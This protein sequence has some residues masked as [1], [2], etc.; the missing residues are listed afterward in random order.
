MSIM[1]PPESD[2]GVISVSRALAL[3]ACF[4]PDATTLSLAQLSVRSGLHKT[5]ALRLARTLESAEYLVQREGGQW[6]LGPSAGRLGAS[7]QATF[8][9]NHEVENILRTL[10]QAT[11]ESA[12]LYVREGNVRICVFRVEGPQAV[13]HHVR[14]G[15][16]LPLNRGAAGRAIL[17]HC[18]EPGEYYD[19][20]RAKGYAISM[21]ER[22][23][24][25][26]SAAV[27]VHGSRNEL[28]GA[29][30]ISG[31]MSRLS[32]SQL[33]KHAARVREASYRLAGLFAGVDSENI[34]LFDA[35]NRWQG[36]TKN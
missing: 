11:R 22:E 32:S 18:G 25:V 7:Y 24:D 33:I 19:N 3:L 23:P 34:K 29:I 26:A 1:Q 31:P 13:R 28:I 9:I 14:V 12:A 16:Q 6:R 10:T 27:A 2:K 5:T 17:A 8:D 15:E 21:G 20:V 30:A 35:A 36:L 4:G